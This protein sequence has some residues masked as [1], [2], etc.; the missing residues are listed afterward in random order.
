M[1]LYGLPVR[2]S[3][4]RLP[5]GLDEAVPDFRRC[6][7]PAGLQRALGTLPHDFQWREVDPRRNAGELTKASAA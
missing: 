2:A 7:H 5:S 1:S 6:G 3:R 4:R